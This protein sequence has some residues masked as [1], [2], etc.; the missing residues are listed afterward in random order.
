ML[1]KKQQQYDQTDPTS[2]M[3]QVDFRAIAKITKMYLQ[4][5]GSVHHTDYVRKYRLLYTNDSRWW[6]DYG[7]NVGVHNV[8]RL[9][10]T[11]K[12]NNVSWE[13]MLL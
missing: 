13:T 5:G 10:D 1:K 11:F 7:N 6:N 3:L 8:S 9:V 12:Y 4:P 2:Y